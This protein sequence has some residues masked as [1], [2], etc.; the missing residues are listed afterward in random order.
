MSNLPVDADLPKNRWTE[1]Q[2]DGFLDPV[3]GC[4]SDGNR[5][6]GGIPLDGLWRR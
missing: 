4:I 2:A 1:I 3:P 6:D 5:L